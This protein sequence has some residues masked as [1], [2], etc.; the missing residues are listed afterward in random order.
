MRCLCQLLP[1][2]SDEDGGEGKEG[3]PAQELQGL[4][5]SPN[6]RKRKD[7]KNWNDGAM[8]DWNSVFKRIRV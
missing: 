3:Y 6:E 2:R 7:I 5:D 8:E 4:D 1:D